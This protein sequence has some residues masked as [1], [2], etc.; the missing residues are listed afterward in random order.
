MKNFLV[1]RGST[2]GPLFLDCRGNP[3]TRDQVV[4]VLKTSIE[5]LGLDPNLFNGH[6]LRIGR[7]TDLAKDGFS[8]LRIKQVGRWK[9]NAFHKYIRDSSVP[10]S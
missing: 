1:L 7:T 10:P 3:V 9:S 6:S 4:S 2:K 5:K 8:A